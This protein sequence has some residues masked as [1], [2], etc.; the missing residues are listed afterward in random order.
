MAIKH[1]PPR[2][3]LRFYRFPYRSHF[4]LQNIINGID[5]PNQQPTGS[6]DEITN[7]M[8]GD[9]RHGRRRHGRVVHGH[10]RGVSRGILKVRNYG[11][12]HTGA[13]SV[14]PRH[15]HQGKRRSGTCTRGNKKQAAVEELDGEFFCVQAS[16][17]NLRFVYKPLL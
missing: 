17:R 15:A 5:R 6:I 12:H 9:E 2:S 8:S 1:H 7:K 16:S 14:Q 4:Y 10:L 11:G 13:V 3:S